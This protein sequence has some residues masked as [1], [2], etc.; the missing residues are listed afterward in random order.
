[1]SLGDF[2][3]PSKR[4]PLSDKRKSQLER[5]LAELPPIADDSYA[6][7]KPRHFV[8]LYVRLHHHVYGVMPSELAREKAYVSAVAAAT[9]LLREFDG[10]NDR[11]ARFLRWTWRR[12]KEREGWRKLNPQKGGGRLSWRAQFC[13]RSILDDY[14]V[15]ALRSASGKQAK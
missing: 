1:M 12:E 14:R 9:A 7:A 15:A 4:R 2:A 5:A 3:A 6:K 13:S 8:A 10:S 11:L